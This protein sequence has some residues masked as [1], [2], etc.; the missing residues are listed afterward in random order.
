[1]VMAMASAYEGL[2]EEE[3]ERVFLLAVGQDSYEAN[4]GQ[5]FCQGFAACPDESDGSW[6]TNW[7]SAQRDIFFYIKTDPNDDDSWEY[8]C[9]Y[10]MNTG[11][12]EFDDTIREM[13]TVT[14]KIIVEEIEEEAFDG[15]EAVGNETAIE[16]SPIPD[17]I[18]QRETTANTS[19]SYSSS[20]SNHYLSLLMIS[21]AILGWSIV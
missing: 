11:K 21:G 19:S 5:N 4:S 18:I 16:V 9:H 12:D 1:M 6:W 13:L 20:I 8:Y 10:S 15:D 17:P 14:E 3:R 2:S 7:D